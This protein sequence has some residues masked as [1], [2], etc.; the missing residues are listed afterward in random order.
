MTLKSFFSTLTFIGLAFGLQTVAQADALSSISST[1]NHFFYLPAARHMGNVSNQCAGCRD[2]S[3]SDTQENGMCRDF[4]QKITGTQVVHVHFAFGYFD[5]S[6]GKTVFTGLYNLGY[7]PSL[8]GP[9]YKVFTDNLTARCKGNQQICRFQDMGNGTFQKTVT[10][11]EGQKVTFVVTSDNSSLTPYYQTNTVDRA[12]EQR[13]KSDRTHANFLNALKKDEVVFYVGH[14]RNGG[15]PDF[16]P[17][18]LLSNHEPDYHGYYQAKQPGFND[19]LEAIRER[20][21][22][23]P[24]LAMYSCWS[25]AWF[26][27][28]LYSLSPRSAYIFTQSDKLSPMNEH[29]NAAMATLDGLMRFQCAGGLQAEID[30]VK[31]DQTISEHPRNLMSN[32]YPVDLHAT[33]GG[34]SD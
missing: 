15:G 21:E 23:P 1:Y 27:R 14:S 20:G 2:Q 11:P 6:E 4:Y 13:E 29:F 18:H 24:L 31:V 32:R 33:P 25:E 3:P 19:M 17:P 8:D 5:D 30:S 28:K 16:Y 12:A 10:S 9:F 34:K 7:N 22:A 26:G